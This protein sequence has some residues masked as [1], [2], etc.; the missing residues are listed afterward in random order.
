MAKEYKEGTQKDYGEDFR[1]DTKT[2]PDEGCNAYYTR[3]QRTKASDIAPDTEAEYA[4]EDKDRAASESDVLHSDGFLNYKKW[5]RY[6]G[7][8]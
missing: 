5:D 1:K 3:K 4:P 2:S 8:S 6:G 7:R